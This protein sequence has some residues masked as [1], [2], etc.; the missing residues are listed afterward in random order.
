MLLK[1]FDMTKSHETQK[2]LKTFCHSIKRETMFHCECCD[3]STN[4]K[5]DWSKHLT[6]TSHI[7]KVTIENLTRILTDLTTKLEEEK[8][9][10]KK[11]EENVMT[12]SHDTIDDVRTDFFVKAMKM[13]TVKKQ[14]H[15]QEFGRW[16]ILNRLVCK[17][18]E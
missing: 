7:D 18:F 4:L 10:N 9:K 16:I 15:L 13:N 6:R 3:Y 17:E 11:L 5:T 2:G 12:K 1:E 14:F 8:I